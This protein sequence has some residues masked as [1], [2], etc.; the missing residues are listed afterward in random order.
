MLSLQNY[1]VEN[2]S[3]TLPI[4]E[5]NTKIWPKEGK[6]APISIQV[7]DHVEDR[8]SQR[9]V[10]NNEIVD[11]VYAA[12]NDIKKLLQDGAIKVARKGD[13]KQYTFVI[14][15]TKKD[16][17]Y[18]LSVVGFVSWADSKFKKMNVIIK[19][20]A[21]YKDFAALIR[22]DNEYEKHIYLY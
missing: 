10:T 11:A 19:T 12:K 7:G 3:I 16:P 9:H 8:K 6:F 15:D 13:K 14:C 4:F 5:A 22:K 17:Q 1:I 2:L 18:P 20:V 21:K